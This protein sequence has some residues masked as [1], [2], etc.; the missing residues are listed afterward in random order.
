MKNFSRLLQ[1]ENPTVLP[2][3]ILNKFM[4]FFN[5]IFL[6]LLRFQ[7]SYCECFPGI[8]VYDPP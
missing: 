5:L 2:M 3:Y 8:V 1:V 7:E 4:T 6:K